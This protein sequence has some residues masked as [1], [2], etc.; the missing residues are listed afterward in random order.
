MSSAQA[1]N[2]DGHCLH[3]E[4]RGGAEGAEECNGNYKV[5]SEG[6]WVLH[7]NKVPVQWRKAVEVLRD[8]RLSAI[9]RVMAF[10][11]L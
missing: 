2:G 7:T 10:S 1:D 5:K 8:L 9:L 6:I 4:D 3:A 11:R